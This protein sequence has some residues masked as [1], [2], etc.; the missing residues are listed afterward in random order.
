MLE[1]LGESNSEYGA[2]FLVECKKCGEETKNK[3]LRD[4]MALR[5]KATCGECGR[6]SEFSFNIT[7]WE[8][9]P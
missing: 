3:F 6:S 9:R 5:F 7:Q 2:E 1:I 8:G 4:P